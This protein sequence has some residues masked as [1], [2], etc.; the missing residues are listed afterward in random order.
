MNKIGMW[1]SL[2]RA[3]LWGGRGRWF[4]SSHPDHMLPKRKAKIQNT[5]SKRQEAIVVLEDIH[6]PHNAQAVIRSCDCFGIQQVY[7]IFDKERKFN[8]KGFGKLSSSSANKWLDFKIFSTTQDAY[9][10]LKESSYHIIGT[11]IET[12]STNI[13]QIDFCKQSKIALVFGNEHE[14][15]SDYAIKNADEILYI[16][17]HGMV[18]SLN[19]SVSAAICLYEMTRQ[20][21]ANYEKFLLDQNSQEQLFLKWLNPK[22]H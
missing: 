14:G 2:A 8:P 3:L 9:R 12:N 18:Q 5:V 17:M 10:E 11:A 21:Y 22:K 6:D 16:P 4:K 1:L 13:H 20:R 7:L 19:L 15:L